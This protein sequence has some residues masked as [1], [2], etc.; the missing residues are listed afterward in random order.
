MSRADSKMSNQHGQLSNKISVNN[1][2][3]M[4][5]DELVISSLTSHQPFNGL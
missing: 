4:D 2:H 1:D 5:E 3:Q